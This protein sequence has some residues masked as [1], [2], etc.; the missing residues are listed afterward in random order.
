MPVRYDQETKAEAIR[1]VRE[2]AGDYPSEYAAIS[3]TKR[4]ASPNPTD[5]SVAFTIVVS[6]L[7]SSLRACFQ[8][9]NASLLLAPRRLPRPDF[10]RQAATSF[11]SGMTA[12]RSPIEV[13][14]INFG[15]PPVQGRRLLY[16]TAGRLGWAYTCLG[17]AYVL[18]GWA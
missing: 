9:R 8:G 13:L 6:T 18:W 3:L 2:H 4:Q 10:H 5:R 14:L 1:L 12:G 17:W 16:S 11:R 7:G 15:K